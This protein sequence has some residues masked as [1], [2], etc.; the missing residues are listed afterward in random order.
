M[1]RITINLLLFTTVSVAVRI[2]IQGY[3]A[4][5]ELWSYGISS[6]QEHEGAVTIAFDK[7]SAAKTALMVSSRV[8]QE[9]KYSA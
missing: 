3:F 8:L 5:S 2:D 4:L 1:Y 7:S 9:G 6:I